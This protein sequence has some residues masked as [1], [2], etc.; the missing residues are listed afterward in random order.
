ML[1][2][3]D[4]TAHTLVRFVYCSHEKIQPQ[5]DRANMRTQQC[6]HSHH[7]ER[8]YWD[9]AVFVAVL[10]AA[11]DDNETLSTPLLVTPFEQCCWYVL[12]I[13]STLANAAMRDRCPAQHSDSSLI[14]HLP[15]TLDIKTI[16]L[17]QSSST[18]IQAYVWLLRASV[19]PEMTPYTTPRCTDY[20][21]G[22][23]HL[24]M[25]GLVKQQVAH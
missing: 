12:T 22:T 23:K 8:I 18:S 17:A 16:D 11:G 20:D 3:C 19:A 13:S 14:I 24:R 15:S 25:A 1:A 7:A 6:Y 21:A 2:M 9:R 4:A 10:G 5:H